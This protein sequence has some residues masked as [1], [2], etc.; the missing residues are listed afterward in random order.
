MDGNHDK[1]WPGKTAASRKKVDADEFL[2]LLLSRRQL[3]RGI[4]SI[5]SVVDRVTGEAFWVSQFELSKMGK[6]E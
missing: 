2:R 5:R 1:S 4:D 3:N 6:S